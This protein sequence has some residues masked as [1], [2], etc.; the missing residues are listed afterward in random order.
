ML[1][2]VQGQAEP[3][4]YLK[5]V[6][7]QTLSFPLL[8]VGDEGVGR[9][10]SVHQAIKEAFCTG[11]RTNACDCIDCYQLA[12]S[13]HPDLISLAVVDDKDI[14]IDAVREIIEKASDAPSM[15]PMR[16]FVIDGA[17]RFTVAA[18]NAFLKTLE[19]PPSRARFFLLTESFDQVLPTIRSRC[20]KVAYGLLPEAFVQSVLHQYEK[21]DA[22]ALV[23]SR[24]G[25]GSIGRAISYWGSGRLGLRDRVYKLLQ[26]GL[27]GDLPALFSSLDGLK[28]DLVLGLRFL[29]HLLHDVLMVAHDPTRLI[30]V[31]LTED[32][33]RTRAAASVGVWA[34]LSAGVKTLRDKQRTSSINVTFHVKT[35]FVDTF[36]GV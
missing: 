22:K 8:L 2:D 25:E 6:A 1:D 35:L 17:D 29:E 19:E 9:R 34:R 11:T 15:A 12:K 36:A 3:V 21:D 33:A 7:A 13:I 23:Y 31:D 24:M 30:N 20:G 14:G 18:A 16:V 4:R 5:K 32:L 27:G 26:L 10:F 28:D